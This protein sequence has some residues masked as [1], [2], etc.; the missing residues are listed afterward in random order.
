ML[1]FVLLQTLARGGGGVRRHNNHRL[2]EK[3][4]EEGGALIKMALNTK[5]WLHCLAN[6]NKTW[7]GAGGGRSFHDACST[8][9]NI[10]PQ[11]SSRKYASNG[12]FWGPHREK[13]IDFQQ[14]TPEHHNSTILLLLLFLLLLL[15]L[16]LFKI[17]RSIEHVVSTQ[18]LEGYNIGSTPPPV[19]SLLAVG[20]AL[21]WRGD[22][23]ICKG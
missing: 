3:Y 6:N 10:W 16:L 14:K 20:R 18:N 8:E 21:I 15:W 2:C 13:K 11:A 17:S 12:G 9:N 7:A 1:D 19:H 22:D 5:P 23:S 4:R